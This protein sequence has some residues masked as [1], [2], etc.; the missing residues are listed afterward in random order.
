M[1]GIVFA[2]CGTVWVLINILLAGCAKCPFVDV[3]LAAK[4]EMGTS[5]FERVPWDIPQIK[6]GLG[7]MEFC[8][9]LTSVALSRARKGWSSFTLIDSKVDSIRGYG[10]RA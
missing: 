8:P 2:F 5:I 1:Q 10:L 7:S 9:G 6:A 3:G 4:F